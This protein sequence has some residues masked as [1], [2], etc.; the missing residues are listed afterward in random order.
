MSWSA[1][2][3]VIG[4]ALAALPAAYADTTIGIISDVIRN[5]G[6]QDIPAF[7]QTNSIFIDAVLVIIFFVTL[8]KGIGDKVGKNIGQG[9]LNIVGIIF[10]IGFVLFEAQVGFRLMDFGWIGALI[11]F[12]VMLTVL[13]RFLKEHFG[14]ALGWSGAYMVFYLV[15]LA[16]INAMEGMQSLVLNTEPWRTFWGLFNL[17]F[18][19]AVLPIF[20]MSLTGKLWKNK[21]S[22]ADKVTGGIGKGIRGIQ[23][24][25]NKYNEW[26]GNRNAKKFDQLENSVKDM[27]REVEQEMRGIQNE[28][29]DAKA[30]LEAVAKLLNLYGRYEIIV[31]DLQQAYNTRV[32]AWTAGG[33]AVEARKQRLQQLN[34]QLR[35]LYTIMKDGTQRMIDQHLNKFNNDIAQVVQRASADE[36]EAQDAMREATR[37]LLL[38][39]HIPNK[40]PRQMALTEQLKNEVKNLNDLI[41]EIDAVKTVQ[42]KARQDLQAILS[43]LTA[44]LDSLNRAPYRLEDKHRHLNDVS[45]RARGL[46]EDIR[47]VLKFASEEKRVEKQVEQSGNVMQ[48]II[49]ELRRGA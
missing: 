1:I 43:S 4:G 37:L 29:P 19:V 18:W 30:F 11:L 34:D 9:T 16:G 44:F 12:V 6:L 20:F 13:W 49:N 31:K 35:Q 21:T 38:M 27:K 48:N 15:L 26:T 3:L 5:V 36:N 22:V 23:E 25:K 41:G 33:E 47:A 2:L 10:A 45:T 17:V 40:D 42:T 8:M 46:E 32:S 7:Y 24:S 14:A 39:E 28:M